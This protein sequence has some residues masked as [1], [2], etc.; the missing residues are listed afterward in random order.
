[1]LVPQQLWFC[2]EMQFLNLLSLT[3]PKLTLY[4]QFQNLLRSP[5]S[6]WDS[7][8]LLHEESVVVNEHKMGYVVSASQRQHLSHSHQCEWLFF[9]S[10]ILV[11]KTTSF[12]CLCVGYFSQNVR[13]LKLLTVHVVGG[14]RQNSRIAMIRN[15]GGS[16]ESTS[17][18]LHDESRAP[19]IESPC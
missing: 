10:A 12:V 3:M 5:C 14:V 19:N 16:D 7:S 11:G 2:L 8:A 9:A 1:M 15:S 4:R 6:A 18:A 13:I 17:P